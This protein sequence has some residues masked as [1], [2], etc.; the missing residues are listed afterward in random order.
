MGHAPRQLPERAGGP[1]RG[2][3]VGCAD[4]PWQVCT[5]QLPL[6]D[7]HRSA[8]RVPHGQLADTLLSSAVV[9]ADMSCCLPV[10]RFAVTGSADGTA[11]VWDLHASAAMMQRAHSG[12][13]TGLAVHGSTAISY[14]THAIMHC[15]PGAAQHTLSSRWLD[16]CAW[17]DGFLGVV[18]APMGPSFGMP[19]R[20]VARRSCRAMPLA[21]AGSAL[22]IRESGW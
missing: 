6:H 21:C 8:D 3:A 16:M 13:V 5:L 2:S 15:F 9:V 19:A 11:R 7:T 10:C 14:G 4:T 18:Q 12:R 17:D 22:Q 1:L 20:V